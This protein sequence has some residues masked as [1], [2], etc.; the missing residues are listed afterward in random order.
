VSIL[1]DVERSGGLPGRNGGLAGGKIWNVVL[2][3]RSAARLQGGILQGFLHLIITQPT[4]RRLGGFDNRA[5]W[6]NT[7]VLLDRSTRNDVVA[8]GGIPQPVAA[9][10]DI[11]L[12]LLTAR[13]SHQLFTSIEQ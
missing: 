9:R 5:L 7:T 1:V 2:R 4:W 3:W 12:D 10:T 6:D 11:A 8:L 13:V